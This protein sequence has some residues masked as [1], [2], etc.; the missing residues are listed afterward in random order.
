MV[1]DL[2][3][4]QRVI[5][6]QTSAELKQYLAFRHFFSHAYTFDVVFERIIPLVEGIKGVVSSLRKDIYE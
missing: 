6:Q 3:L 1:I 5:S 2:A 4:S